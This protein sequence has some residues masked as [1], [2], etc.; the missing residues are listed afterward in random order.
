MRSLVYWRRHVPVAAAIAFTV[1]GGIGAATAV[2]TVV[3]AV[4]VRALPVRD[5]ERLV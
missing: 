3:E 2:Y 1:A 4:V 5:P